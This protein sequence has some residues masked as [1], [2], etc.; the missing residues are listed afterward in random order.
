MKWKREREREKIAAHEAMALQSRA[1][2]LPV[3]LV[4][5]R[6]LSQSF[7]VIFVGGCLQFVRG[8]RCR[9]WC[10]GASDGNGGSGRMEWD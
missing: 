3:C 1:A 6:F 9:W 8:G 4:I 10:G 5:V 2:P 7:E